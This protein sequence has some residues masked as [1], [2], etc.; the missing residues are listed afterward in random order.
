MLF[1]LLILLSLSFLSSNIHYDNI[2]VKSIINIY[3]PL[4]ILE[5]TM[6]KFFLALLLLC[7]LAFPQFLQN[8][9]IALIP[10][11]Q[12]AIESCPASNDSQFNWIASHK[13]SLGLKYI[14]S[15]G[16]ITN[17]NTA[18]EWQ[19][20]SHS[21]SYTDKVSLP[22]IYAFGNHDGPS[23]YTR[24]NATFTEARIDSVLKRVTYAR[25]HEYYPAGT[26]S[27]SYST[28]DIAGIKWC[29]IALQCAAGSTPAVIAWANQVC[30][31]N[32]DRRIIIATHAYQD[33]KGIK[34]AE[35]QKIW[36]GLVN[37][38][39]NI[40]LVVCG[41][42][43]GE[44]CVTTKTSF[45]NSVVQMLIDLQNGNVCGYQNS[46]TRLLEF[47]NL[48]DSVR[49]TTY[50]AV[51]KKFLT[52]SKNKFNFSL[53]V[54]KTP[55]LIQYHNDKQVITRPTK[56]F[57]YNILGKRCQRVGNGIYVMESNLSRTFELVPPNFK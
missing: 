15:L 28:F 18:K 6:H 32:S 22:T 34:L 4:N 7:S 53:G 24:A 44:S 26:N 47:N 42:W 5:A 20:A 48:N 10:D 1:K 30:V 52:D 51:G 17:N 45:G 37:K 50:S 54:S 39:N 31:V 43:T 12:M 2:K 36:D 40:V 35:G 21:Y 25:N 3:I 16:D 14:I 57:V 41:H 8:F 11:T 38:H 13:D 29:L 56:K 9:T 19:N 33:D 46:V 23:T 49:A 55:S 27:N